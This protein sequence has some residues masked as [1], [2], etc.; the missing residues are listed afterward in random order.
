MSRSQSLIHPWATFV[1]ILLVGCATGDL[2]DDPGKCTTD[3]QCSPDIC[4]VT[5]GQCAFR[6]VTDVGVPDITQTTDT[7]MSE[8][9]VSTDSTTEPDASAVCQPACAANETCQSA[10]CVSACSP[11]CEAPTTCTANGC[12]LPSCSAAGAACD[13][14]TAIQG[15]FVCA[16]MGDGE[17]VCFVG[18]DDAFRAASCVSGSYCL[19]LG[20]T[21]PVLGCAPSLCDTD[22]DCG[23]DTCVRFDNDFGLCFA[24]GPV[25]E[26]ATCSSSQRC[27]QGLFCDY[28]TSTSTSGVCRDLC[29]PFTTGSCGAGRFCGELVS[30]E[31]GLCTDV[32]S[33]SGTHPFESCGP[34]G[35]WCADHIQCASFGTFSACLSYCRGGASDCDGVLSDGSNAVCDNYIYP[36]DRTIGACFAPCDPLD[37]DPCGPGAV[38]VEAGV[39]AGKC[40]V[41]CR[42]DSV[43]ADCCG[44][45][46]PCDF[47][48]V[49]G[50]CE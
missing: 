27:A 22:A 32:K 31:Q 46:T 13:P 12:Q 15:A 47:Q 10:V 44:E 6:S 11:G 18:C 33:A 48:C 29:Q 49:N 17:G 7:G 42:V 4:N 41:T 38:C 45:T 28:P 37:F 50:L 24:A 35:S 20:E 3:A 36:G 16:D 30:A 1:G 25:S 40:R 8:S 14:A 9:E 19:E 23:P 21:T 39:D 26:G 34:S 2:G 43:A 5:T